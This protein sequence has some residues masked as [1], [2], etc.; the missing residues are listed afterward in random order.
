MRAKRAR[1]L[2]AQ[3]QKRKRACIVGAVVE[4]L[5]SIHALFPNCS[6]RYSTITATGLYFILLYF[7]VTDNP[8]G[9]LVQQLSSLFST[10]R[11][12]GLSLHCCFLPN[13]LLIWTTGSISLKSRRS[14]NSVHYFT[15]LRVYANTAGI[16]YLMT[17]KFLH[18]NIQLLIIFSALFLLPLPATAPSGNCRFL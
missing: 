10:I 11:D 5:L 7:Y 3:R 17:F 4:I 16:D 9:L 6:L 18:G 13:M 8:S 1:G 15:G 12:A 2:F 14:G